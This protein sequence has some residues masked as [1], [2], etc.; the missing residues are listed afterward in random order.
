MKD[1]S[2]IEDCFPEDIREECI[3][4]YREGAFSDKLTTD[5]VCED[6]QAKAE[7][8]YERSRP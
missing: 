4:A 5:E 7:W 3:D 8:T 6:E 2:H 1:L